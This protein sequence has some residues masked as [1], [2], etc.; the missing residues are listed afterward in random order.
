MGSRNRKKHIPD[1]GSWIPETGIK[2]A[3]DSGSQIPDLDPQ[4]WFQLTY[5][6]AEIME[7]FGFF[8]ERHIFLAL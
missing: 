5:A 4:H 6:I 3:P 1:S 7:N 2:K 8:L